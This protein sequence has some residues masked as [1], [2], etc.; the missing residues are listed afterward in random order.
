MVVL[1]IVRR[2]G[3]ADISPVSLHWPDGRL[4]KVDE[5]K[6]DEEYV[7]TLDQEGN[8]FTVYK[9]IEEKDNLA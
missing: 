2:K 1:Q 5:L 8:C 7:Y 3:R 6:A 9:A 4:V